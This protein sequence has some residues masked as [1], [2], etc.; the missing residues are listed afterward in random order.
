MKHNMKTVL[1]TGGAGFI[2][3]HVCDILLDMGYFVLMVDA[4]YEGSNLANYQHNLRHPNYLFWNYDVRNLSFDKDICTD[5]IAIIHGAA[6][7]HVDR[8]ITD[9]K[10]FLE[11]NV[12]G[13]FAM[14]E[15]ARQCP[16]LEKFVYVNTDEVYGDV[17][18][19][20]STEYDQW[21]PSSPY[22]ASKAAA[23]L[24]AYSYYV[25]YD[26]PVVQTLSSNNFGPRQDP[27]KLIPKFITKLSCGDKVPLMKSVNNS[28]DWIYVLDNARAII[29]A[30]L[31]STPGQCYNIGAGNELSNIQIT[32][33]LLDL[34][35]LDD[36]YIEI[37]P[38]RL[39]HDS[40]Y[41]LDISKAQQD[42][43]FCPTSSFDWALEQT[44]KYYTDGTC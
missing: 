19:G 28:R 26:L 39:G 30:M 25:T 37:V 22:A 38:D 16:N 29:N 24:L 1:V 15:F 6:Q 2:M 23:G 10:A 21:N 35:S 32:K 13:T 20:F 17:T 44:M 9:P 12:M 5:V 18:V 40:R 33:K 41:A 11:S 14:L 36:S 7:S 27:E 42:L 4:L 34:F 31:L 8:S 43:R 3:S